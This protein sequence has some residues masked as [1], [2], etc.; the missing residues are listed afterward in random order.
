MDMNKNFI[1]TGI[2]CFGLLVVGWCEAA[3]FSEAIVFGDSLSDSG[4]YFTQ[5][6]G[7]S[8]QPYETENVP[9][10][11][12]AIGGH[13]FTNGATWV[14]KLT[15][16][17][18]I[19]NSGS[20][21]EVSPGL[22]RNYAVG[23]SR[24]RAVL[25]DGVFSAVNLTTQ[26][27][28]FLADENDQAPGAALYII[29]IG[30]NDVADA[31]F[32]DNPADIMGAALLNTFAQLQRLYVHGARHFLILNMP[33]F[34]LTPLVLDFVSVYP[35]PVQEFLLQNISMASVG[36][37]QALV[38]NLA[39]MQSVLPDM[40]VISLDVFSVLNDIVANPELH[41]LE[42]VDEACIIPGTQGQAYCSNWG[43]YLFWDAQ[44]PTS[45]G[46][47]IIAEQAEMAIESH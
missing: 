15:R 4:N 8:M 40:D 23:R 32:A 44:H 26:V 25:L 38:G 12:Y 17:L 30:S 42:I 37:N 43:R 22:F 41:G 47:S 9:S 2:F 24:A 46:H 10:E 1:K 18:H 33:D 27:D 14:E 16:K 6:G 29:W 39:L 21:S 45:E 19:P 3:S 36:Y 11:P 7:M 34:A 31:L 28:S 13:R 35:V 20:P 5:F